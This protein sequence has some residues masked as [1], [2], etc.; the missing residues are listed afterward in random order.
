MGYE[1]VSVD[2]KTED[3][4]YPFNEIQFTMNP[5]RSIAAIAIATGLAFCAPA[6]AEGVWRLPG[7]GQAAPAAQTAGVAG[8]QACAHFFPV[9]PP[10][11]ASP[12]AQRALCFDEFAVL[13]SGETKTP[14]YVAQR[15]NARQLTAAQK[16]R[17]KDRF[18]AEGRLPRA[19]RAELSDYKGSGYSRGHMAPTGEMA[20]PEGKAQSFSLAN[21]VPQ[22]IQHN[23]GAWNDIE[24]DTRDYV[25]RARGDVYVV[26]GPVYT[27]P[28]RT[29]GA[30]GVHVPSALFKLVYDPA[31]R[32]SWV[33]WQENRAG[34]RA[35]PPI[36]YAEFVRRTGLRFLPEP[37][38]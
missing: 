24:K 3:H 12:G 36:P 2:L 20:T 29:I 26:T 27:P 10:T 4:A 22:D 7:K 1:A 28:A 32:R 14:V 33:H 35:G 25:R 8:F 18:Y 31:T 13:H 17:R 11:P 30:G 23:G 37:S 21:M 19:E 34:T 6:L 38:P 5:H 9:A 15:L 16:L